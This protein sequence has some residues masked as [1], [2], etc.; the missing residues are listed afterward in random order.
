MAHPRNKATNVCDQVQESPPTLELG[1]G[2]HPFHN[3]VQPE[4]RGIIF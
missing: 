4:Q 1:N 3:R 2:A